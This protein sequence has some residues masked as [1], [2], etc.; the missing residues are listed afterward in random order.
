MLWL[1]SRRCQTFFQSFWKQN[2]RLVMRD[3]GCLHTAN[4][5]TTSQGIFESLVS[6][7]YN[8]YTDVCMWRYSALR[9]DFSARRRGQLKFCPK[10]ALWL[11][12]INGKRPRIKCSRARSEI[13]YRRSH[14]VKCERGE[15]TKRWGY[16]HVGLEKGLNENGTIYTRIQSISG[17][18]V[19]ASAAV[20]V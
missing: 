19:A 1:F 15:G 20:L 18:A 6:R 2:L 17:D 11:W 14:E 13:L 5:A 4:G 8:L 10:T 12:E 3:R 16:V 7:V 9:G